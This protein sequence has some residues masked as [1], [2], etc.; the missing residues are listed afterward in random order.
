MLDDDLKDL[1]QQAYSRLLAERDFNARYCQRLMIAE[2]ARMLGDIETD[3]D[4]RR[5]GS[6]NTCVIE[7]GT[8]T[9]KTIAYC[10]AAIPLAKALG[11]SLVISTATVALQE[12][13]VFSDLPDIR[14]HTGLDFSFALAKGRRR[15]LCLSKLDLVLQPADSLSR[16]L[17]LYQD[18]PAVTGDEA[19]RALYE[20]LLDQLVEGTWDG[21]RD[22]FVD[23]IDDSDWARVSTDHVQCAGRKCSNFS[24]CYF[25]KAR[26][27]IHKVD[28]IVTNHDLVLSD[29]IVGGGSVLPAP[30]DTIYIFDEG[31]H[32]PAKG[33]NHFANF[34]NLVATQAWLERI[35]DML[36]DMSK[37]LGHEVSL[38]SHEPV[39]ERV[40][41]DLLGKL[42]EQYQLLFS[43]AEFL[44]Q[45]GK[46]AEFRFRRGKVDEE[47]KELSGE[48]VRGYSSLTRILK[49]KENL[50]EL[51]LSDGQ[52]DDKDALEDWYPVI[53][54][55]AARSESN[56][57]LWHDYMHDD[58]PGRPPKA[59]WLSISE[60]DGA[61]EMRVSSSPVLVDGLLKENLWDRCFAAVITSATLSVR[62]RFDRFIMESG[63]PRSGSFK[64]LPSPFRIRE[65]GE[66]HVPCFSSDPRDV[67]AHTNEVA[68]SLPGLLGD[69]PGALVLFTSWRQMNAV[70]D[71]LEVSFKERILAQGDLSKSEIIRLHKERVDRG[72]PSIIFG[73]ASF[74][75]GID[76]PGKYCDH[77]VVV[78]LPFSVPDDPVGATLAE[79]LE[80]RGRNAFQEISVPDAILRLTQACGRLL[81]TET[82]TGV[83]SL[84]DKRIVTQRYGSFIL[85]ALPPFRRRILLEVE[86]GN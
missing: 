62:G 57:S 31:H 85:D 55:M 74:A 75:E 22:T 5:T 11:K 19:N 86:S 1:I 2:I 56:L 14:K 63:V 9:G 20:R 79:W 54:A 60:F 76:L 52:R 32:L 15:Y 82:D 18:E 45:R 64:T 30:E 61:E 51:D 39:L 42:G 44:T 50:L 23:A 35:P 29:L 68:S 48:L 66:L 67:E 34:T 78:K 72:L 26:E 81:R 8:G 27:K 58:E 37:E 17:F 46:P 16:D 53:A 70:L 24:N 28:C 77:V 41:A 13:I 49:D 21:D 12:Q 43:K 6:V 47:I 10:L 33:I 73:L 59:R 38:N 80:A 84:L 25:F 3:D 71:L 4:G 83:I 69:E 40:V 36:G 7:A 65:Q